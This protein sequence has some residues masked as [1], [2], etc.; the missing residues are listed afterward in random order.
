MRNFSWFDAMDI[1]KTHT[2]LTLI[3]NLVAGTFN[4]MGFRS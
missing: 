2:N 3:W 1:S 4:F